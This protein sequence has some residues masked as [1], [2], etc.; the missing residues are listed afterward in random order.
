MTGVA[1]VTGGG[2]GIGT[3][4]VR[5]LYDEGYRLVV[6]DVV[7]EAAARAVEG[8]DPERTRAYAC[9]ITDAGSLEPVLDAAEAAL[10]HV[11]VLVNNAGIIS[12]A[13]LL[14]LAVED[15]R[16]VLEVNVIGVFVCTQVVARRMVAAGTAGR[17]VNLA[18]I[19]STSISTP[20]LAHYAA[21][22]GAV[23]MLTRAS[24][25]ELAPMGIRVNAVAPGVVETPLVA[26]ALA[27]PVFRA[28][29]E[30]RI[31]RG[32]LTTPAD[33]A[34]VITMLASDRAAAVT[35]VTVPVDGGEHIGGARVDR[36]SD[37]P[38]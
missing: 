34:E 15:F 26:S 25:L 1:V 11:D 16:R 27:D 3:A 32:G 22:K 8:L 7:E 23:Q 10:G 13:P 30:G 12:Y 18:S 2:G 37:T 20:D 35:G 17:I 36:M 28:H 38:D 9:D 31:P 14:E 6:L 21:S 4:T 24:A 19:N 33:V 29:W 5:R